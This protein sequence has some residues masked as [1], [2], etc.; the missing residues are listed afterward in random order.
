MQ[1]CFKKSWDKVTK[2]LHKVYKAIT[3]FRTS[4]KVTGQ[5]QDWYTK[6]H[7]KSLTL[8]LLGD[9]T[10]AG[11]ARTQTPASITVLVPLRQCKS[12]VCI[13]QFIKNIFKIIFAVLIWRIFTAHN[14]IQKSKESQYVLPV[15]KSKLFLETKWESITFRFSHLADTLFQWDL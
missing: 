8:P 10:A 11:S 6:C 1:T 7:R 15:T 3:A 12:C 4:D 13:K 2:C 5:C 9:P 14:T